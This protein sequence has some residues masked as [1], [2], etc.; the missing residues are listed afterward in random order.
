M[1]RLTLI[2][3]L[4]ASPAFA[5]S[6]DWQDSDGDW[7]NGQTGEEYPNQDKDECGP[8]NC[9][10]DK[11]PPKGDHDPL[12]QSPESY[13]CTKTKRDGS[14]VKWCVGGADFSTPADRVCAWYVHPLGKSLGDE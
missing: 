7:H 2:L 12:L 9:P 4:L 6:G 8:A 5:N 13:C 14:K 10:P 1:T 3:A 11:R